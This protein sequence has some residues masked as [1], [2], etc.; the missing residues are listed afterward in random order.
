[1]CTCYVISSQFVQIMHLLL[2]PGFNEGIERNS[3]IWLVIQQCYAV[4][5]KK[6]IHTR[7]NIA[8]SIAQLILPI[9]FAILALSAAKVSDTGDTYTPSLDLDLHPFP[10]YTVAYSSGQ[11]VTEDTEALATHYKSQFG[12]ES[13]SMVDRQTFSTMDDFFKH[14]ITNVGLPTFNR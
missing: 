8:I 1:M 4:F 9:F 14:S 7:R 3:G 11:N 6:F 10:K 5:V 13:V 12:G 2:F